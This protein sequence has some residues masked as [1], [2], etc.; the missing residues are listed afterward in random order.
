MARL[1]TNSPLNG[2]KGVLGK[3]LVFRQVNGETIVSYNAGYNRKSSSAQKK[4]RGKFREAAAYSKAQMLIP[5]RKAY[6]QK[7]AKKLKLPNAY[8][9]AI[10]EYMRKARAEGVQLEKLT[11]GKVNFKVNSIKKGN[12]MRDG[13]VIIFD[14]LRSNWRNLLA[15]LRGK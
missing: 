7:V 12:D 10:T 13:R 9:A 2:L 3:D 11:E 15:R 8:T 14:K 6:Y 4:T 5:E 1:V